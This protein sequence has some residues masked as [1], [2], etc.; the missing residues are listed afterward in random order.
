MHPDGGERHLEI[1]AL[2]E[3]SGEED[4]ETEINKTRGKEEVR[5]KSRTAWQSQ[6]RKE[7][8]R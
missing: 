3:E 6:N 8:T 7:G 5:N 1:P 4:I 2:N